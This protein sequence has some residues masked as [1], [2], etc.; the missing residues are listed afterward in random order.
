MIEKDPGC[1]KLYRLQ[2]IHLYEC[3]LNLLIGLYF[4]KIQQHIEDRNLLN[5][6]CYGGQPNQCA[7]DP[8]VVDVTQIELAM[9]TQHPI[10]QC[11]NHPMS[12]SPNKQSIIWTT[13]HHGNNPW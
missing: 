9:V 11:N 8:V 7:N 5:K 12:S 4:Q 1:P 13:P 3:D 6:G 2:V 10:I